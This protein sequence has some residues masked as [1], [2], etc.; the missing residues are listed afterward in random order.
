MLF[1]QLFDI[2]ILSWSGMHTTIPLLNTDTHVDIGALSGL[3]ASGLQNPA[4]TL[5][6]L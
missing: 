3:G 2:E 6:G 1:F 4:A 5:T